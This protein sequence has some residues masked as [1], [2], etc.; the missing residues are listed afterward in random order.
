MYFLR[1]TLEVRYRGAPQASPLA[2]AEVHIAAVG[3]SHRPLWPRPR[4][5]THGRCAYTH[6]ALPADVRR[7][8]PDA[9]PLAAALDWPEDAED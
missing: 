6:D 9:E 4:H 7:E 3:G 2:V 5:L 8:L 1:E